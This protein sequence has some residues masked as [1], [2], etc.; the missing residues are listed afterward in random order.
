MAFKLYNTLTRRIELFKPIAGKQVKMYAC[1]PTIYWY[2]HIGNLRTYIFEDLLKR[3]LLYNDFRVKHVMNITD[4][5][6]LTS[7]A[8]TG[9]E[10]MELA[11]RR[12][13]KSAWEIAKFYEAAFFKDLGRLN[14]IKPDIVCRA[15]GHIKEQIALIQRLEKKG[16]TYVIED[17]VYFDTSKLKDYGKLAKLAI[18]GLKAG[19]RIEV[20]P[21]K[22]NATDFALWKFSPKDK[23]R[24]MEWDFTTDMVVSDERYKELVEISKKNPNVQ[25]LKVEDVK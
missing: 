9:E 2:A 3:V 19:A 1:G 6:H 22:K 21:G 8:D 14:I 12:E 18:K 20:V 15:T 24:E 4:V 23:K 11:A 10:K 13:R 25:I 17:G 16:F 7:D 5:G